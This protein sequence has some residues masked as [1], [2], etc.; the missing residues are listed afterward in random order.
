MDLLE[1]LALTSAACL[2]LVWLLYPGAMGLLGR[3]SRRRVR[4]GSPEPPHRVSVVLATREGPGPVLERVSNLLGTSYPLDRL[5]VIVAQDRRQIPADLRALE[6]SAAT[7]RRVQAEEPGK[8]AA[9]NA[10]VSASTGELLVFADTHQRFDPHTI[11][12]LVAGL[13]APGV[14]V[15][16]GSY[17]LA[18]GSGLVV[19]MYWRFERWLRRMEARVHSSVGATGAVYAMRRSLW[20]PLPTGLILDD[21]FAPMRVVLAGQRVAFAEDAHA[22]EMRAPSATQEY[23]RKVRTLTGVLQLCAWLPGVLV[24]LRN[25]IWFQFLFHKL[26]RLLTPYWVL[27]LMSWAVAALV[28]SLANPALLGLT[29]VVVLMASWLALTR[30]GWGSSVRNLVVEAVLIQVAVLKAGINGIRGHWQVWDG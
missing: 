12:H 3:L 8:A 30:S 18:P 6:S 23:G 5:E 14:G 19:G 7:I 28:A 21:V 17:H 24:P 10:G 2:A 25:P 11:P 22:F 4:V 29:G 13:T 16:T 27:L 26:L 20:A 1:G 9:L 15:V